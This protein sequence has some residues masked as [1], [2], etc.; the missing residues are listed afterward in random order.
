MIKKKVSIC[1][2]ENLL[3]A[4]DNLAEVRGVSRS[5]IVAEAIKDYLDKHK[6]K[7]LEKYPAALWKARKSGILKTHKKSKKGIRKR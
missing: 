1:L 3:E 2:P 5:K 4:L 6:I 7:R